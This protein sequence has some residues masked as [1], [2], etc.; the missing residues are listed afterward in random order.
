MTITSDR[1]EITIRDVTVGYT[2]EPV[3]RGLSAALPRGRTTAVVGPNG[4]GKS[5]LLSAIAGVLRPAAGAVEGVSG[6]RPAFVAQRSAVSDS[7]PISVRDTVSMGRWAHRG[8]WRRLT[9]HDRAV[10][11]ECLA[12]LE[13]R[14]LATRRLGSLSGGQ[15]QRAL[16]AQGLA[17]ESGLLLLDEPGTGLD[18]EARELIAEALEQAKA[19]GTTVVQV[20]HDFTEARRADHCLVLSA[21]RLIAEGPPDDVLT[22]Q[23]LQEVWGIRPL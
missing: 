6:Q 12:R 23:V 20:T 14:P 2:R 7:L 5:T 17:Q 18:A 9:A 1:T 19:R 4:S 21:G 16:L 10:V 22:P 15:R 13:L 8:P 3:L 11:E